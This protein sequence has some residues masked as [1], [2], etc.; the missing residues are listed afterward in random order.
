MRRLF[1]IL[2]SKWFNFKWRCQRFKRGYADVDVW[3]IDTW[4]VNTV[5]HMLRQ[6]ADGHSYPMECSG[7]EEWEEILMDM[8]WS[9]W[10]MNEDN[11]AAELK[12][13]FQT[14]YQLIYKI[15]NENKDH[16]FELFSKW[17]YNLW[18]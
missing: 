16:F 14:D 12:P 15:M 4:F 18:D 9:L 8:Y 2:R 3:G 5:G 11:V 17:F 7:P 6:L 1:W 13:E 10:H